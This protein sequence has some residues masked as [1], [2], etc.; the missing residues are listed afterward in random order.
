MGPGGWDTCNGR[1][2]E[3]RFNVLYPAGILLWLYMKAGP[4]EVK[5]MILASANKGW[6]AGETARYIYIY[7]YIYIY[8]YAVVY[9][10]IFENIRL[11][12]VFVCSLTN[13]SVHLCICILCLC[14]YICTLCKYTVVRTGGF[15]V[16]Q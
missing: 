14:T 6:F 7:I 2:G 1:R 12:I 13:T 9:L 10:Y 15:S 8:M 4:G 16:M 5:S 3:G 11:V